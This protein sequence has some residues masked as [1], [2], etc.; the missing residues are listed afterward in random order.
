[1]SATWFYIPTTSGALNLLGNSC[2]RRTT[3]LTTSSICHWC[4]RPLTPVLSSSQTLVVFS[5]REVKQTES[6]FYFL[7]NNIFTAFPLFHLHT[8]SCRHSYKINSESP[9]FHHMQFLL[10]F[11]ERPSASLWIAFP[12]PLS[13]KSSCYLQANPG[14]LHPHYLFS[15]NSKP[16]P[17]IS[18]RKKV[19]HATWNITCRCKLN[20]ALL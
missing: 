6:C 7:T 15:Y 2:R 18:Q 14:F 5:S 1:M 16:S 20:W 12:L 9:A 17:F 13:Q 3:F 11:N 4:G 10:T 19:I 8:S